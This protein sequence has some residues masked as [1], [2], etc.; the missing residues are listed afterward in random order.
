MSE[1]ELIILK[2]FGKKKNR[3]SRIAP[4]PLEITSRLK[5]Q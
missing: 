4:Q 1:V 3:V 2:S 5:L